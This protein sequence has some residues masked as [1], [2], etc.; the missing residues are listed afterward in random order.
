[1]HTLTLHMLLTIALQQVQFQA[2]FQCQS[3]GIIHQAYMKLPKKPDLL[4][5]YPGEVPHSWLFEQCSAILHHGGSGTVVSALL[6]RKPQIICPVMF[7]QE[8]WAEQ[9][10]W[11]EL[12]IRCSSPK[13]LKEEE[14]VGALKALHSGATREK[15]EEVAHCLEEEDGIQTA[16]SYIKRLH[17]TLTTC[18]VYQ[19]KETIVTN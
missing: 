16:L 17:K 14:L 13:Q 18:H 2:I 11:R 1:M 19:N 8:F 15:I 10:S 3:D 7:D 9:L 5:L 4:H 12:A 6:S